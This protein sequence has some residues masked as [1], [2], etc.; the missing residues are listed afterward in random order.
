MLYL[1]PVPNISGNSPLKYGHETAAQIR[2]AISLV[3][4][5]LGGLLL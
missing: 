5:R 3:I 2:A 1:L 4:D